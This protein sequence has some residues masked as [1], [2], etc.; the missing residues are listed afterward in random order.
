MRTRA[1]GAEDVLLVAEDD[2]DAIAGLVSGVVAD[3]APGGTTDE[4][5]ALYVSPDRHGEGIGASLLCAA[6]GSSAAC[7]SSR[8]AWAS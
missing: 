5:R 1:A 4:I 2:R 6:A 7:A 3:D 8:S